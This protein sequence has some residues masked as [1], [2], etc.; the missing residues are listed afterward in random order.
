MCLQ[1]LIDRTLASEDFDN[2]SYS[3]SSLRLQAPATAPLGRQR[4]GKQRS[5]TT[6]ILVSPQPDRKLILSHK[7]RSM[8]DRPESVRLSL[9]ET[10]QQTLRSGEVTVEIKKG[11]YFLPNQEVR[12]NGD[13]VPLSS[14]SQRIST[15]LDRRLERRVGTN[16]YADDHDDDSGRHSAQM[17]GSDSER[18]LDHV[19]VIFSGNDVS[20]V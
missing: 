8:D 11:Q 4:F 1:A 7:Q 17:D 10:S 9:A 5:F 15:T 2:D 12:R 20:Y 13:R 19:G 14:H 18:L 3:P 16:N 6:S